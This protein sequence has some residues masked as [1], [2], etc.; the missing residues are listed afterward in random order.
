M[1]KTFKINKKINEITVLSLSLQHIEAVVTSGNSIYN[2]VHGNPGMS[3]FN[4]KD[5]MKWQ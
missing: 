5:T 3:I 4:R 1:T 2:V